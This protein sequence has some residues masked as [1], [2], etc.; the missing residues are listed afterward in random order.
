MQYPGARVKIDVLFGKAKFPLLIDL[1]FGDHFEV[2][3]KEIFLLSNS[4]GPLF[5][6]SLVVKCYPVE[7]IFAEKLE[8]VVYRGDENSRMKDF[9][10]LYTLV[11][12]ETVLDKDRT[13]SAI[14]A[15]FKHRKTSLQFPI[16]F[17]VSAVQTLQAYWL[18]YRQTTTTSDLIPQHISQVIERI[19]NW[20]QALF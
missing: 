6:P 11:L 14:K 20:L 19:N 10:D 15:V 3:E 1:G 4:K 7:F 8:T 18:R 2:R 13:Q 12:N 16:S 17:N 5:E 9:H